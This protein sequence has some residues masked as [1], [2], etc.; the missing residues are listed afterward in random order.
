MARVLKPPAPLPAG[1]TEP[2]LF[3]AGSIE[4]GHAADWQTRVQDALAEADVCILNPRRDDWDASWEQTI[5]NPQFRGQVE[6][7][8]G[9]LER[10]DVIAFYFAPDTKAPITLMEL[11]LCARTG[12]AIV[13]CPDGYWRKGNVDVVC[14]RY[15]VAQV[16]DLDALIASLG[17]RF[18]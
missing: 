1:T 6:W 17:E 3:L 18:C 13:A 10:A 8:L 11:G 15:G 4:M 9:G 2:V 16:A 7:E 14:R 5:D 12:K